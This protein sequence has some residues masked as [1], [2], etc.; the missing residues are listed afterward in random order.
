VKCHSTWEGWLALSTKLNLGLHSE[1]AIPPLYLQGR[2]THLFTVD[3]SKSV[4]T[5]YA[6]NHPTSSNVSQEKSQ[7]TLLYTLTTEYY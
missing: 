3:F 1:T 5:K 6:H 7:A 4:Y 2:G